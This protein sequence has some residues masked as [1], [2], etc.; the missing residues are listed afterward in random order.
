[1]PV[2]EHIS[3]KP[4]ASCQLHCWFMSQMAKKRAQLLFCEDC[5]VTLCSYYYKSFH[6][7]KNLVGDKKAL[8]KMFGA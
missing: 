8:R 5:N 7:V 4:G 1:M 3:S 6:S 2:G